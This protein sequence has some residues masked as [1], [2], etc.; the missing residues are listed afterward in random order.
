MS[1]QNNWTYHAIAGAY[2]VGLAPSVYKFVGLFRA[3]KGKYTNLMP[4]ENL[5]ALRSSIPEKTWTRLF[6]A[7]C[8]HLN[9]M[10]TLPLFAVAM[11]A[12]NI[13]KV[14]VND[15]NLIAAEYVGARIL[16]TALYIGARS[17]FMSYMRSSVWA[18]SIALPVYALVKAGRMASAE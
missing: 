7:Q 9:A 12:G 3:S 16:Y 10:E 14:P 5:D 1:S 15:L 13:T 4:R 6:R 11:I 2:A 18:W 17:E 8:A